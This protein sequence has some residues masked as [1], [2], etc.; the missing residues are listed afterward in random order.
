MLTV[1]MQS[2]RSDLFDIGSVF[3]SL[4]CMF[5]C[6]VPIFCNEHFACITRNTYT[7][8]NMSVFNDGACSNEVMSEE[9]LPLPRP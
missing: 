6:T 4:L 1:S 5:F 3:D 9:V 7:L 8:K 2:P